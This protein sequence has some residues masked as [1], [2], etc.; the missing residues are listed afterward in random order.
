M[1]FNMQRQI[2]PLL[3]SE[4][5][6]VGTRWENQV[7][8]DSGNVAIAKQGKKI[9]IPIVEKSLYQWETIRE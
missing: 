6:I 5:C 2:V 9:H 8:L 3:E 7:A 4:K 1:G